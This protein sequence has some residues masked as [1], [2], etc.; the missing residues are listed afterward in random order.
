MSTAPNW[1]ALQSY[2]KQFLPALASV[3][4]GFAAAPYRFQLLGPDDTA[5]AGT[6]RLEYYFTVGEPAGPRGEQQLLAIP[7]Q[8]ARPMAFNFSL[9]FLFVYDRVHITAEQADFEG[10]LRELLAPPAEGEEGSFNLAR[11]PWLNVTALMERSS[12]HGTAKV[13]QEKLLSV[14]ESNWEGIFN[15]RCEAL[16]V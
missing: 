2:G 3:M 4:A 16:P 15:I 8:P 9:R 7:G 13:E 12:R 14:W 11:L 6:P 10:Q 5:V 1:A